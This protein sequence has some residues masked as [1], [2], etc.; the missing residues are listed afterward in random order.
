MTPDLFFHA[1][2]PGRLGEKIPDGGAVFF[3]NGGAFFLELRLPPA[4]IFRLPEQR[5]GVFQHAR[6]LLQKPRAPERLLRFRVLRQVISLQAAARPGRGVDLAAHDAVALLSKGE[7]TAVVAAVAE[8]IDHGGK[9]GV[10][11]ETGIELRER[12]LQRFGAQGGGLLRGQDA[13]KA[14]KLHFTELEQ[15]YSDFL[16]VMEVHADAEDQLTVFR[17]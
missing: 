14:L 7:Q 4:E 2:V 16:N 3:Q 9:V 1:A 10:R 5:V 15:N 11:V 12:I 8:G 13:L 17:S 6:A